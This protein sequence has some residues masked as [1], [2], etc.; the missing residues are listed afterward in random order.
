MSFQD[1]FTGGLP[2]LEAS[3]RV[4]D[5]LGCD[6][7]PLDPDSAEDRLTLLSYV[8]PDQAERPGMLRAALDIARSVPAKVDRANAGEWA[9]AAL[10]EPVPGAATVLFH[11]IVR[12]YMSDETATRFESAIRG[13]ADQA[14]ESAPF[15]WLRMEPADEQADVRLTVWPGGRSN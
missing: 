4:A 7:S 9:T 11:S 13:A 10:A 3:L 14:T 5:R 12:Q 1:P 6:R 2:P 8:W 15:A